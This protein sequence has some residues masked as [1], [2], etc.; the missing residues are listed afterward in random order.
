MTNR[1]VSYTVYKNFDTMSFS[2]TYPVTTGL[3]SPWVEL[4]VKAKSGRKFLAVTETRYLVSFGAET[5]SKTE[6]RSV[7]NDS[8]QTTATVKNRINLKSN[9][10][11]I[12]F[13]KQI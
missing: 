3:E 2:A 4:R 1:V 10:A 6:F 5:E 13:C 11:L 7:S 9:V 8:I 12:L